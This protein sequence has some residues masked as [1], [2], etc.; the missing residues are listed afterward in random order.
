[1]AYRYIRYANAPRYFTQA[2]L[3]VLACNTNPPAQSAALVRVND[4][5]NLFGEEWANP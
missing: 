5:L 3:P 2:P 4:I 1:M